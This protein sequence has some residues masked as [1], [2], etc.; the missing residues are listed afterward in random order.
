[1]A[2]RP[3]RCGQTL[4]ADVVDRAG[5][6]AGTVQHQAKARVVAFGV[7]AA[8]SQDVDVRVVA[9]GAFGLD[10]LQARVGEH[11]EATRQT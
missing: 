2:R 7:F 1:M 4:A 5:R 8:M 6:V 3:Q 9:P 10:G 11:G